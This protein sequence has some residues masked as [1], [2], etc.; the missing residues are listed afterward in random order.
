MSK[1]ILVCDVILQ[2]YTAMIVRQF[3]AS[4]PGEDLEEF[5]NDLLKGRL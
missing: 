2:S 4:I 1:N 5:F 3:P